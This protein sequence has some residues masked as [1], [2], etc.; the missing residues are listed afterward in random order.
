MRLLMRFCGA[1]WIITLLTGCAKQASPQD[2][3]QPENVNIEIAAAA[4]IYQATSAEITPEATPE[5]TP[6]FPVSIPGAIGPTGF[7]DNVNPL[8][9]LMV[10]DPSVLNRR[11]IVAKIS[12]A[13]ALVRPQSGIG[14]ADLV[15]EHYAEGG[16]TR[17][18]A[19]FY[20]QAPQRVGSIRSARLIDYELVPMFQGL[21]AFSGASIGVEKVIYG[22]ADVATRIPGSENSGPLVPLPPSEFANRT[23]MGVRYGLPTYWRDES[24]P[25]PHNMFFNAAALWELAASEGNGE[26]PVL[27]GMA[28]H[29]AAPEGAA[30]TAAYVDL[31]YRTTRV[32]WHYESNTGLYYRT[33]DGMR[34]FDFNTQQQITTANVV[35]LYADHQETDI[36]ESQFEGGINWSLQITLMGEGTAILCRDGQR[37]DGHWVR[38]A[39]YNVIG[40]RTHDG[41][42]LY[43]KPGVTWFQVVPLPDQQDPAE[44][45]LNV[46]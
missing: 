2:T 28:F 10:A 17:F 21:L 40:L 36:I 29:P 1:F 19:V 14:Q 32:E 13:P 26:R 33:Q 37:Y 20:G 8:T 31:R 24:I 34:H 18:S 43:L 45:S 27:E 22:W 7:A 5:P 30:G 16:L 12:N 23:Y 11:P 15:F 9:G 3:L 39:Q 4:V 42:I 41:Q 46:G 25:V 38:N 6:R 35:I 44:E